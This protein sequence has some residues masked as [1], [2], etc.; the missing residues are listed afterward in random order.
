[1]ANTLR[2][3]SDVKYCMILSIVSMWVFRIGFSYIIAVKMGWGVFGVWVAM[4]IDWV[5]R[6]A[7]F[8]L[9]YR[10]TRWYHGAVS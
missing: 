5:V 8:I 7:L 10:G 6:A 2:A 3:A 1:M 4:T 9:R